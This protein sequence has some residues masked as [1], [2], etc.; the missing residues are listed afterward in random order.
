MHNYFQLA[1]VDRYVKM[2]ES[3]LVLA[4]SRMMRESGFSPASF[5][6]QAATVINNNVQIGGSVGGDVVAGTGNRVVRAAP[7]GS[8]GSQGT[9]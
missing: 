2:M 5:D 9:G 4:V 7:A 8:Q 3:R 1:D 6:Q